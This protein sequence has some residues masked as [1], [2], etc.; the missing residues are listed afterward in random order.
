M[1]CILAYMTLS[2]VTLLGTFGSQL[3]HQLMLVLP[4]RKW[5]VIDTV[6]WALIFWNFAVV[7]V[8][9]VF[10][11]RGVPSWINQMYLIA[12]SVIMAWSLAS[13]ASWTSWVLLLVRS[14]KIGDPVGDKFLDA[15]G[16][17][18]L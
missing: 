7:G 12:I 2:C 10:Y 14:V 6:T 11:Q 3:A 15:L 5:L 4:C 17:C 1:N 13:L 16:S 8:V 9:S 18:Y